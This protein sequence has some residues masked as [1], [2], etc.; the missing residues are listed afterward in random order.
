[1]SF[2]LRWAKSGESTNLEGQ[3]LLVRKVVQIF[4]D[5]ENSD[6]DPLNQLRSA[7]SLEIGPHVREVR[8]L[9]KRMDKADEWH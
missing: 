4:L 7:H 5:F 8:N 3:F 9:G 6:F 2:H 1:M